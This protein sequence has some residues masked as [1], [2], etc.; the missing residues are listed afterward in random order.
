MLNAQVVSLFGVRPHHDPIVAI[1]LAVLPGDRLE[2]EIGVVRGFDHEGAVFRPGD[3]AGV[4]D[5]AINSFAA[6]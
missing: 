6:S 1:P 4:V 2:V 3:E 5:Q